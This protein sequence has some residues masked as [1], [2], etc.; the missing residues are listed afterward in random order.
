MVP[1]D[2]HEGW[3]GKSQRGAF[4]AL[5]ICLGEAELVGIEN[6]HDSLLRM[7]RKKYRS[8]HSSPFSDTYETCNVSLFFIGMMKLCTHACF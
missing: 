5:R 4:F 2:H 1:L 7:F 6:V 8:L 3:I